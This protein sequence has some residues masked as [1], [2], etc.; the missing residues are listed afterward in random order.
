M[1]NVME[2]KHGPYTSESTKVEIRE[3]RV[4][5]VQRAVRIDSQGWIFNPAICRQIAQILEDMANIL[6]IA[7]I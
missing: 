3:W 5:E 4:S 6:E 2:V 7:Q 1:N